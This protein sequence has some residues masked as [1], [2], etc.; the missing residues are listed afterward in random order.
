M[1]GILLLTRID[2]DVLYPPF[3]DKLIALVGACQDKGAHYYAV[4]GTRTFSEQTKLYE[5]GR[6][7][8]GPRVTNA[9]AG[10]SAH[11]F[12]LAVDFVRDGVLDRKGLQ[13]DWKPES[14]TELGVEAAALGLEWGGHFKSFDGPHVQWPG[15]VTSEQLA[16]LRQVF[17]NGGLTAVWKFLDKEQNHG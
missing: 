7:A 2:L 4:C 10:E 11:N 3:V 15:Y 5:Q 1:S 9:K 12:G 8:P 17:E 14:Y 16:P 13:P 6:T